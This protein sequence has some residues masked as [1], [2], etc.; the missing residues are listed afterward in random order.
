MEVSVEYIR[1][2]QGERDKINKA[3]L[4]DI[5]FYEKRMKLNISPKKINDFK[6]V[7]LNNVDF[8]LADF[9]KE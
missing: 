4:E 1:F 9:Y 8:I 5:D 7:G 3:A 6:F 2:L